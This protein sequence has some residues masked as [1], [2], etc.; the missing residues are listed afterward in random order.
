M[1]GKGGEG[2]E[3]KKVVEGREGA[4]KG[5]ALRHFSF[6]NLTTLY[7]NMN[8]KNQKRAVSSAQLSSVYY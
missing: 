6:Y 2:R 8:V 5:E 7:Y 1:E 4:G 3:G